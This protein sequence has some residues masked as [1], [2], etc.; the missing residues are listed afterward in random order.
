MHNA[1]SGMLTYYVH[2]KKQQQWKK[3]GKV[4]VIFLNHYFMLVIRRTDLSPDGL[5]PFPELSNHVY[6]LK[7]FPLRLLSGGKEKRG[8]NEGPFLWK[9]II[10]THSYRWISSIL[11]AGFNYWQR[12]YFLRNTV[13]L[14]SM[15]L[16]SKQRTEGHVHPKMLFSWRLAQVVNWI[17]CAWISSRTP[18]LTF[19]SMLQLSPAEYSR[20]LRINRRQSCVFSIFG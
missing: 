5:L 14:Q 13:P 1:E 7:P 2:T 17:I 4:F 12:I 18:I 11:F 9:K 6:S 10:I 8:L 15:G 19:L 20:L 16:R 3:D